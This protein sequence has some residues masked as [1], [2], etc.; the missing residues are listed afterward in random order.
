MWNRT[1]KSHASTF[2]SFGGIRPGS[3]L[4]PTINVCGRVAKADYEQAVMPVADARFA[5]EAVPP[6]ME[7]EGQSVRAVS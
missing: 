3:A 1:I 2:A 7:C 4:A 5:I 6:R